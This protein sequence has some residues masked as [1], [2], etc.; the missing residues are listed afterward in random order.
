[1]K[2]KKGFLENKVYVEVL[3]TPSSKIH[4]TLVWNGLGDKISKDLVNLNTN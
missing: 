1:M 3:E 4:L 2:V